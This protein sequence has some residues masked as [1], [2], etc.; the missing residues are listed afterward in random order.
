[1]NNM[2]NLNNLNR[3]V[4]ISVIVFFT[5]IFCIR[6]YFIFWVFLPK[7]RENLSSA[8]NENMLEYA[9][10][11]SALFTLEIFVWPLFIIY[12]NFLLIKFKAF[13]R[14]S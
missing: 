1:M 12:L 9:M 6:Y 8:L 3:V 7:Y 2:N 13:E 4:G 5:V 10:S 11:M 14:K